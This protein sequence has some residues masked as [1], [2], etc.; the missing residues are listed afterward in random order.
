M[1]KL[2]ALLSKTLLHEYTFENSSCCNVMRP[3]C[4]TLLPRNS[5][6]KRI[7]DVQLFVYDFFMSLDTSLSTVED[8]PTLV[9]D[10]LGRQSK[11]TLDRY[12]YGATTLDCSLMITFRREGGEGESVSLRDIPLA[13]TQPGVDHH[14]DNYL[15]QQDGR[16]FMTKISIMDLDPK[17]STKHAIKYIDQT[18]QAY[19]AASSSS[20][21]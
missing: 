1:N 8:M 3:T 2:A 12:C 15:V 16:R 18:A 17:P 10:A 11:E 9:L 19:R 14:Y 13:T 6:L 4:W 21:L 20:L 5:I 7:L